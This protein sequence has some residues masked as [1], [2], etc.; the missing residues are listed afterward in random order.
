MLNKRYIAVGILL[1]MNIVNKLKYG[2]NI[3]LLLQT[4]SSHRP[5]KAIVDSYDKCE[6]GLM[7]IKGGIMPA[8]RLRVNEL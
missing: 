1:R 3:R 6:P 7:C 8:N 2:T 4:Y 5:E